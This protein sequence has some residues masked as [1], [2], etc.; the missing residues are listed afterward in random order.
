MFYWLLFEQLYQ[1]FSPFRVFR[2]ITFRAAFAS[3][4]ALFL[5]LVLGPWLIRKLRQFQIGQHIRE[6]GPKSHQKKAGTPTMGGVL[7]VISIVLPTLLW[8]NLANPYVW[9]ALFG[10]LSFGAIGFWDDY[11]KIRNKRNLGLTGRKK[12]ALQCV[13]ALIIGGFLL[14]LREQGAYSTSMNVPFFKWFRPSL[15]IEPLLGNPFTYPLAF[16]FFFLFL[17]LWIVGM[18]NGVNL[19]DGLDGLAIGL[20]VVAAAAMTALTYTSGHAEFARYL[21]LVRVPGAGE[22]TIFCAAMTG[23]CLGFLWYNAHPAEIFM[24]DVGSLALGGSLAVVAVLIKQEILLLFIGGV[25]VLEALSVILQVAS[26]KLRGGKRIFKMAP[27]HHHFEALGWAESKI[28]VRFWIAG[29][30]MALFALTTLKLR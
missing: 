5:C 17:I 23:A 21:D 8:A 9:I 13:V 12:F 1:Y 24:G 16:T 30:V 25:F 26:Y 14:I 10:I 4:T 28:I 18:S 15:V 19:T 27:L 20:M 7:I 2:F 11:T 3:L 6:E 22:L 29:L